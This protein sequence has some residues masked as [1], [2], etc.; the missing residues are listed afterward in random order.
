[1]SVSDKT[2]TSKKDQEM[3]SY[4]G[5][6]IETLQPIVYIKD[7]NKSQMVPT[8]HLKITE[9]VQ[10]CERRQTLGRSLPVN[11]IVPTA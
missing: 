4:R 5:L 8:R 10:G 6:H 9:L 1:M 11:V 7:Q 2:T 3:S